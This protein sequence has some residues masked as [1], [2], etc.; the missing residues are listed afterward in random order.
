MKVECIKDKLEKAVFYTQKATGKNLTLPVLGCILLTAKDGVLKLRSTNLELGVEI[1]V[2]AKIIKE[3]RVSV[4]GATLS[5]FISSVQGDR[6]IVLEVTNGNLTVSTQQNKTIVKSQPHDEFPTIP[7]VPA[8][9]SLKVSSSSL[10]EGF[11][12]VYYS[13]SV[14]S[15]KPEL[16]SVYVHFDD[17][18]MIFVS[19]DSF[20]LAEKK[21]VDKKA[22][23]ADGVLIPAKN[24]SEV[25]RIIEEVGEDVEVRI[26][27]N[28]IAF[29]CEGIYITSRTVDGVFPDYNQIIPKEF[30][31]EA[32]ILRAD[33][34]NILK[35]STIFTGQSN[36][37]TM[38][39]QPSSGVFEVETKNA[40]VGEN[41]SRINASL[42]GN[43][44]V[45]SFNY[46]YILDCFQSIMSDSLTLYFAGENRPVVIKGTTD[47]SFTYLVMPMNK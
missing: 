1:D 18:K 30:S 34:S 16:S 35:V 6:N 38:K 9:V 24:V 37:L 40:D 27:D 26:G 2:P 33:L 31:T 19:T 3:G 36:Q 13:A 20:R 12:S 8:D 42:S 47:N 17:G 14:S 22:K 23:H 21:V 32:T 41:T 46:R 11:K 10:V 5:S 7:Q 45:V 15:M 43:D 4:P 39:I 44:I 29:M 25:V 28:Q